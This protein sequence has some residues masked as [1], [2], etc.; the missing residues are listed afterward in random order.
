MAAK[1]Y[2]A[3]TGSLA[4]KKAYRQYK[5]RIAAL[6]EPYP[7]GRERLRALLH[8]QRRNPRRRCR[9][10][11]RRC[12]TTSPTSGTAQSAD[13][14][15]VDDLVGDDP[16]EFADTFAAAYAGKR[17]IDKERTAPHRHHQGPRREGPLMTG[18]VR[19]RHPGS[20]RRE[21]VQRPGGAEGCRLRRRAGASSPSSARTAQARRRS[22][23]SC[24][25]CRRRMPELRQST[26]ST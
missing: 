4:D 25:R 19:A 22:C 6:P 17:W 18:I 9:P 21:V 26:D 23:A 11:A 2:E 10:H 8:A 16:V 3:I 1:W 5:A 12:S 14:M 15:P 13:A 20:G 24:R 7:N